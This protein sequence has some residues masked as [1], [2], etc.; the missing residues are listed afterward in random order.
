RG[1]SV[2]QLA[3]AVDTVVFDKTGT[4]T[5]GQFEIVRLLPLNCTENALLGLAAAVERVSDHP[6]ARIVVQEAVQ[7]GVAVAAAENAVAAAGRGVSG[8]VHGR[9]IRAGNLEFIAE[10]GA[11]APASFIEQCEA[12]GATA[13]WVAED[14]RLVGAILLR[15]RIR[16]GARACAAKLGEIGIGRVLMLTGD[17]RRAAETIAREAGIPEAESG[18]LPEQKLARVRQLMSEGRTVC[19]AGD[20]INDAPALAAATVGIAVAG[21]SDITAEAADVVYL[22]HSLEKL[23]ELFTT[24]RR[25]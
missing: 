4:I 23:P 8:V 17:R 5:E 1:G 15:D 13:I 11:P 18:L 14:A 9:E 7:R 2:L 25:A 21:A 24:S 6:L 20:G 3:A 19:M 16:E 22:P 10:G 12:M